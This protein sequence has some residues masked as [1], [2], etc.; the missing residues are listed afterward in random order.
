MLSDFIWPILS[1]GAA[2]FS[3]G[4]LLACQYFK[5]EGQYLVLSSRV[6]TLLAFI[7]ILFFIPAPDSLHFYIP[8]LVTGILVGFA[9]TNMMNLTV[10]FGG[11][12]VS[13]ILPLVIFITFVFWLVIRPSQIFE[14]SETPV[15]SVFILMSLAGCVFFASNMRHCDISFEALKKMLPTLACFALNMV[16]AKYAFEHSEFHS[17]VYYYILIQTATV[18]PIMCV[19]GTTTKKKFL[20]IE[21]AKF[22]SR[23]I[24]GPG[25]LVSL[26]WI[27]SMICKNYANTLTPNPAYVIALAMTVPVWVLIAYRLT[28]HEDKADAKA[29]IGLMACAIL[30]SV[31]NIKNG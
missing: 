5:L 14:Y 10:Q 22:L 26:F 7:P 6:F 2:I 3:C 21:P 27:L 16:L 30:L 28:G 25:L 9:D 17:G 23:K 8:V 11:G 15:K 18:V 4:Q 13:R 19:L 1:L 12:V 24:L 31:F 29:G 20:K